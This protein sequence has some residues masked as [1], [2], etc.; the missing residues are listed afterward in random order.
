MEIWPRAEPPPGAG[1]GRNDFL[2]NLFDCILYI[3]VLEHIEADR[4]EL[5]GAARRLA[6]GG[7]LIVLSPAHA[8]LYSEFDR[9]I[10]HC[11]RYTRASLRAAVPS[12]V[13]EEAVFYLDAAGLLASLGN[14]ILLR[15]SLPT[16]RQIAFWDAWL[17]RASQWLD[18]LLG[19][20]LGKSVIG[21][22]RK[23]ES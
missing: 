23:A 6:P 10:G 1:Q 12:K 17:V 13:E 11:R 14:K 15:Q 7:A 16:A 20:S 2:E 3:D 8:W 18:P 21:I 9:Q 4:A 19:H 22:W 5:S